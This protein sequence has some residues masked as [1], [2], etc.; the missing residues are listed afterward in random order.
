[1]AKGHV[2]ATESLESSFDKFLGAP[3]L[4]DIGA[5][6]DKPLGRPGELLS[7][8]LGLV[9]VQDIVHCHSA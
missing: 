1:M 7:Q 5:H 2:E 8:L 4:G 9:N 3:R 6:I